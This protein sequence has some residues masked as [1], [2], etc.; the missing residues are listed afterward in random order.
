MSHVDLG[1]QRRPV[2]DARAAPDHRA[3]QAAAFG[4]DGRWRT[5]GLGHMAFLHNGTRLG[6][7]LGRLDPLEI[8][9]ICNY[10]I[11]LAKL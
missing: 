8:G 11:Y 2:D 9:T 1:R 7:G 4:G 10:I 5:H 6:L 3:Q